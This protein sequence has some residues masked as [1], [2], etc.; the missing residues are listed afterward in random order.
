MA[1]SPSFPSVSHD[2][3]VD[4]GLAGCAFRGP[5]VVEMHREFVPHQRREE[6]RLSL[7]HPGAGVMILPKLTHQEWED[8]WMV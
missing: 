3:G 1:D 4:I 7:L 8:E 6:G 2:P 5:G